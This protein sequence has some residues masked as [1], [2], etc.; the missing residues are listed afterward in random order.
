MAFYL[1]VEVRFVFIHV[2]VVEWILSEPSVDSESVLVRPFGNW[3]Q[4]YGLGEDTHVRSALANVYSNQLVTRQSL[5]PFHHL[6]PCTGGAKCQ[7]RCADS[8]QQPTP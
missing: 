2:D 3:R 8:L 1:P 4:C 7:L 6:T 5:P